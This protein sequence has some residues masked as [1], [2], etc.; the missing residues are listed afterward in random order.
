MAVKS[1]KEKII[2]L[3][4]SLI[5]MRRKN[6]IHLKELESSVPAATLF[7]SGLTKAQK[8]I[9]SLIEQTEILLELMD[10]PG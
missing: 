3:H 5:G 1:D 9:N 7:K 8:E 4:A 2:A 6:E 10:N